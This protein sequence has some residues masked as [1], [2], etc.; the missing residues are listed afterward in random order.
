MKWPFARRSPAQASTAGS[1]PASPALRAS[2]PEPE[3]PATSVIAA[4]TR[5]EW[6]TLP[7][8]RVAS[9]RPITLTAQPRA[10]VDQLAAR[11]AM[12]HSPRLEHVRR[13]DAPSGSFRGVLTPEPAA[14]HV[15]HVP[16]L[17]DASALPDV[18]HRRAAAV[19]SDELP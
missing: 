10:F 9:E 12:V 13:M 3:A 14:E 19:P 4:P 18:G 8:M 16:E 7:P 5:R 11:Q 17:H 1:A 2:T 6:A 15:G